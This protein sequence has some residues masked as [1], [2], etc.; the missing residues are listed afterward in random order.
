MKSIYLL[1]ILTLV[2]IMSYEFWFFE[3]HYKGLQ[4]QL[5]LIRKT[6]KVDM[7]PSY[8]VTCTKDKCEVVR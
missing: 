6:C 1:T 5:E 2:C 3:Q 4:Q 8:N 7:G